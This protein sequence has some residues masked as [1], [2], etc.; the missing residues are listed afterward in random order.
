[1]DINRY[2][3]LKRICLKCWSQIISFHYFEL[4]VSLAQKKLLEECQD[5]EQMKDADKFGTQSKEKLESMEN[6]GNFEENKLLDKNM[7]INNIKP[8]TYDYILLNAHKT[9]EKDPTVDETS[10]PTQNKLTHSQSSLVETAIKSLEGLDDLISNWMSS[11]KCMQCPETFSKISSL[12]RHFR[13]KHAHTDFYVFCC[14]R[15]FSSYHSIKEHALKH[16]N[17]KA[18]N[19]DIC[20]YCSLRSNILKKHVLTK[21]IIMKFMPEVFRCKDKVPLETCSVGQ[22]VDMNIINNNNN[23]VINPISKE[24]YDD[25][26]SSDSTTSEYSNV[27]THQWMNEL[28]CG[29]CKKTFDKLAYLEKHFRLKHPKDICFIVCCGERYTGLPMIEEHVCM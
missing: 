9:F 7:L 27:L 16:L 26:D 10:N 3:H 14:D 22:S 6:Y 12:E 18:Y 24:K 1:M 15:K 17:S 19:C 13:Q 28:K 2:E 25:D 23:N 8:E 20:G 21:H 4:S 29:T 5:M 11:I